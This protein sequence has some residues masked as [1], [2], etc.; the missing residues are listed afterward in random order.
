VST[1]IQM[2]PTSPDVLTHSVLLGTLQGTFPYHSTEEGTAPCIVP[3]PEA[4]DKWVFL[5]SPSLPWL[6]GKKKLP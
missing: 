6:R 3:L 5:F 4:D 1:V 2:L